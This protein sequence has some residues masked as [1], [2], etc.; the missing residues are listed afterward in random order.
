[1]IQLLLIAIVTS[2]TIAGYCFGTVAGQG[3]AGTLVG[4]SVG[5][6]IAATLN[7]IDKKTGG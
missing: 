7:K 6:A 1:M 5:V 3:R 4:G 2:A